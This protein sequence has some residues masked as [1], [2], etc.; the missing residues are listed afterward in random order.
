M[1]YEESSLSSIPEDDR[2]K[3]RISQLE[4]NVQL[5]YVAARN[6]STFAPA[7]AKELIEERI[8]RLPT[9]GAKPSQWFDDSEAT[10]SK[11]EWGARLTR[12]DLR[13]K[14]DIRNQPFEN[15]QVS[16]DQQEEDKSRNLIEM[17]DKRRPKTA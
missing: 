7:I 11:T 4:K 14:S 5:K 15:L 2:G 16:F 10:Q 3:R 1:E 8:T 12:R 6:I 13:S 17:Q 9:P